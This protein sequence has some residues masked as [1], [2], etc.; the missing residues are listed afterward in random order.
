MAPLGALWWLCITHWQRDALSHLHMTSRETHL[1]FTSKSFRSSLA[2]SD[3]R[4]GRHHA[5]K[6]IVLLHK[7]DSGV[8][9]ARWSRC[10]VRGMTGA[11][12]GDNRDTT[13]QEPSPPCAFATAR[14]VLRKQRHARHI[15]AH[16]RAHIKR[17]RWPR[18][19]SFAPASRALSLAP[20]TC[21]SRAARR[22]A[23]PPHIATPPSRIKTH[24]SHTYIHTF[25][26][27]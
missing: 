6:D 8:P 22:H 25:T 20:S 19:R 26:H 27:A 24:N 11:P 23:L 12:T 7:V 5:Y 10:L 13:R 2:V 15:H 16:A 21:P 18:P 1:G 3:S 4:V 9:V 14:Q 17:R